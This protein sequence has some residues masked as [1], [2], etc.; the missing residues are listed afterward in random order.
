MAASSKK[1]NITGRCQ[2]PSFL[3]QPAIK[4]DIGLR[5]LWAESGGEV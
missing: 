1:V 5:I 4:N 3:G 2:I